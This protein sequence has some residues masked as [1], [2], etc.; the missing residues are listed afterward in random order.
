YV[1]YAT[2]FA[3]AL[4][5]AHGLSNLLRFALRYFGVG[6]TDSKMKHMDNKW[7][8]IQLFKIINGI[9]ISNINDIRLIQLGL[10]EGKL[11]PSSFLLTSSWGD[12]TKKMPTRKKITSIILG[13][14]LILT[15]SFFWY[16]QNS[17][18][19][20]FAKIDFGTFTYYLSKDTLIIT[21]Q[22]GTI[23]N[24]TIHSKEDCINSR[25]LIPNDSVFA[26]ACNKLLNNSQSY[27]RWLEQE[28]ATINTSKKYL[29]ALAYI[30]LT[31]GVVWLFSLWQFIRANL[32]VV[33]YKRSLE[34]KNE[35]K[36]N[37][38]ERISM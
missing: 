13:T 11:K 16:T 25:K 30:Y 37:K 17:I 38:E 36:N 20:G 6:Y 24:A 8:D 32:Q 27:Q 21:S 9:N 4:N 19:Y 1:V 18:A 31:I 14:M 15:G 28:I 26:L 7:F 23:N 34:N 2:L 35:I 12:I 5:R 22:S 10:N 3:V 29:L 33:N